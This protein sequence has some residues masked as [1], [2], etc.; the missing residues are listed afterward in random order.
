[1]NLPPQGP[2]FRLR[3]RDLGGEGPPLV[4]LHGLLGSSRNWQTAGRDLAVGRRVFAV[5]LR[6]HGLSPHDDRMTYAAM[7]DD[8]EGW[9]DSQGL[10]RAELLGHSMGGKVAMVIACRSPDRV[11]RL[12]VVD[13]APR[14]YFW[15]ARRVEFKAMAGIDLSTLASRAEAERAL[16]AQVPEWGVRKFLTTN[17]E[18]SDSGGWRWLANLPA[19]YA[20]LSDLERNPLLPGDRYGGPALFVV[21]SGSDYVRPEDHAAILAHFPGAQIEVIAGCGHNPHMERREAFVAVVTREPEA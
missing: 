3:H 7:A 11:S 17:L 8:V 9:L 18:R 14:D 15:P 21:G 20:A 4:I 1:M 13:I 16:E 6:N 10:A 5:D 2:V 19:I 12:V